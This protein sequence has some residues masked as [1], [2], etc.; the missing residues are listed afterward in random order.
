MAEPGFWDRP[1]A[2]QGTIGRLK[3]ARAVVEPWAS[4]SAKLEDA[5]ILM[6]LAQAESDEA[7]L[8]EVDAQLETLSTGLGALEF[9]TL[10]S[11]PS[12]SHGA[13]L[14]VQAGAGGT[15]ACDWAAMLLRM[16]ARWAEKMG[17]EIAELDRQPN[18]EAGIR[19]ALVEV[20]GPYAYGYLKHETGVHRLVRI[21][22][23]DA[24]KRRQ[25]TFASVDVT[26]LV[27]DEAEIEIK[28]SDLE[29][30]TY[31]AGGAGGQHVNKTESAVRIRHVPTGIVVACQNERSQHRNKK[32]ALQMLAA[33]L[34]RLQEDRRQADV[35]QRYD[36][37]GEI[38]WGYQIRS[39]VMQ[40][41]QMVKDLRTE[42]ETSNIEAV[43]DGD[44]QPF[45]EASLR[46][47][48]A[49]A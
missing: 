19:S 14:Q 15:E 35:A 10:L 41:Y 44:L 32:V 6:D 21:S 42:H 28:D 18:I 5:S 48:A 30:D 17:F 22:P 20:R 38:A 2:A 24:Q 49:P 43:L 36:E 7:A 23:F 13:F 39:Y 3:A 47:L 31:R 11:G 12:D 29:I 37:K 26:P 1:E 46:S 4:F 9:R 25:T 16:Y 33:K 8:A 27:E 45:M 40:P 34:L